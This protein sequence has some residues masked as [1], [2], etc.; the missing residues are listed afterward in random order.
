[1]CSFEFR[2]DSTLGLM[3][4]VYQSLRAEGIQFPSPQKPKK[5]FTQ[6]YKLTSCLTFFV[7][8]FE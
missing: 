5:E 7:N 2:A 3:N 1:M 6:V 8:L 4:E